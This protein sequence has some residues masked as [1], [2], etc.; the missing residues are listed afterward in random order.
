M[1]A[2]CFFRLHGRL[3]GVTGSLT[4]WLQGQRRISLEPGKGQLMQEQ[5]QRLESNGMM[6]Q[7][8]NERRWQAN[9]QAAQQYFSSHGGLNIKVSYVM[10]QEYPLGSWLHEQ[11]R[12]CQVYWK[13]S[14]NKPLK[15][16]TCPG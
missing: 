3:K 4:Q 9:Y 16:S 2:Y 11:K 1:Q 7:N 10:E 15:R 14:A 5:V 6:W 8:A 13:S 12:R